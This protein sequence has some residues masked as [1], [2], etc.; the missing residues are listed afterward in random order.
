MPRSPTHPHVLRTALRLRGITQKALAETIGIAS[1]TIEKFVNGE[2]KISEDLGWRIAYE[3]GLD[4]EQLMSNRDPLKPRLRDTGAIRDKKFEDAVRDTKRL[5]AAALES[6]SHWPDF[7]IRLRLETIKLV[8]EYNEEWNTKFLLGLKP[9]EDLV[10]SYPPLPR[11]SKAE[12]KAIQKRLIEKNLAQFPELHTGWENSASGVKSSR[13]D[14]SSRKPK[15][16]P[17]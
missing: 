6:A 4:F 17:L 5:I 7:H 15:R 11:R 3:A 12:V 8:R 2:S 16:Q 14:K 9:D 13:S 1:V 10:F